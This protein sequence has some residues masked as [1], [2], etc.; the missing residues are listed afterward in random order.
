MNVDIRDPDAIRSLRPLEVVTYLRSHSWKLQ[1]E[2]PN[3][4]ASIWTTAIEEE[5]YEVLV[6]FDISIRDFATRMAELLETLAI[7]EKRSQTQIF[8]DLLTTFADV[9]RIR[10]D[11]P[12]LKDGSL[13]IEA[14][15]QV[16]QRARD[17]LLAAA[18]SATELRPVWHTRKPQQAM[19]QVKKI[20]IGQSERGSYI[21][22]IISKVT[23]LLSRPQDGTL[24]ELEQPFER[25]VTQMLATSLYALDNAAA[26][27]AVSGELTS[28]EESVSKGVNANLCDAVAGLWE[29]DESQRMIDFTFSWSPGRPIGNNVPSHISFSADRIPV[30]RE[31]ARVMKERAPVKDFELFGQVVKLDREPGQ[32]IGRVTVVGN[33]DDRQRR[34]SLELPETEYHKAVKAHDDQLDFRCMGTLVREGRAHV[35]REPFDVQSYPSVDD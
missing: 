8:S 17:L 35:L 7:V 25:R 12:E 2:V 3:S 24:F 34:V 18:C 14:Y 5:E 10:L 20:R 4:K 26:D 1:R 28:F 15:A 33:V 27:A 11:D 9:I 21:V 22:T 6:P 23:P 30:I 32:P 13:P 19:E 31:A 16:A 29:G